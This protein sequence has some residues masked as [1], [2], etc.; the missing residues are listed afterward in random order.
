MIHKDEVDQARA[1]TLKIIRSAI[2]LK[3][4]INADRELNE[5]LPKAQA[6]FDASVMR[7]VL[8]D[9]LDVKKAIGL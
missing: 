2:R 3:H 9:P 1:E 5:V 6:K 7:G 8:P 4:S